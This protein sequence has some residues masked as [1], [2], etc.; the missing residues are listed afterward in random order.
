MFPAITAPEYWRF[1]L[2]GKRIDAIRFGDTLMTCTDSVGTPGTL[3]IAA[4][5]CLLSIRGA[6]LREVAKKAAVAGVKMPVR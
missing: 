1:E 3:T 6:R 4:D 2:H 5:S